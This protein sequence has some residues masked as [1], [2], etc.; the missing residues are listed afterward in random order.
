MMYNVE[1][2][3][4]LQKTVKVCAAS[5]HEAHMIASLEYHKGEIVLSADDFVST[6]IEVLEDDGYE[7]ID[8]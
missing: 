4:T 2:T 3:E 7:E 6:N 1:I 8:S 5:K